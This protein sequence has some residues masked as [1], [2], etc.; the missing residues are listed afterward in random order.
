ME[1]INIKIDISTPHGRKLVHEL[2]G[3]KGVEIENP[4]PPQINEK[5]HTVDEAYEMMIN[6]VDKHYGKE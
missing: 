3:Q 1:Q 2:H 4:V 6:L 5:L